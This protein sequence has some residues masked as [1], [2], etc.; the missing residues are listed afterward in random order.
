MSE[1]EFNSEVIKLRSELARFAKSL[2]GD[3]D[4]A[5]DLVQ[6]TY[7]KVYVFKD[8][9]IRYDNLKGGVV[10]ILKNTFISSY[11]KSLR[12][13][14]IDRDR[15]LSDTKVEYPP[16][17]QQYSVKEIN[18]IVATLNYALRPSF[19]LHIK[20]YTQQEIATK[21]KMPVGTV[22]SN[23]SRARQKVIQLLTKQGY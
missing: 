2:T 8:D 11:L 3:E 7:V 10:K 15:E 1:K 19:Q 13:P 6:D 18:G 17:D 9:L 5:Q 4:T 21:L 22:K 20:G 12:R 16:V 23:V 14:R